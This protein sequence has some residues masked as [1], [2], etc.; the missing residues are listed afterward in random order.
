MNR[1]IIP[2]TQ[3]DAITNS[4][5]VDLAVPCRSLYIVTSGNLALVGSDD[6]VE[7]F[8]VVAGQMLAC[9]PKRI[10]ATSSTATAIA[11]S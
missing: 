5:T 4:D 11:V 7:V 2:A 10:N 3:W 8:P 1:Q 9:S 6:N